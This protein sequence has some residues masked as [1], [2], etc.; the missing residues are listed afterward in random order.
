MVQRDGNHFSFSFLS[1][2]PGHDF[3]GREASCECLGAGVVLFR[4][5]WLE[6]PDTPRE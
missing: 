6:D 4:Q 3:F 1:R 5:L 2:K